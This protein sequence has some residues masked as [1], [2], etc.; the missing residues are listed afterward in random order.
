MLPQSCRCPHGEWRPHG[1][2][3]SS[4]DEKCLP[5]SS[6]KTK[7]TWLSNLT[8]ITCDLWVLARLL[9]ESDLSGT[10]TWFLHICK[11]VRQNSVWFSQW[12]LCLTWAAHTV[13]LLLMARSWAIRRKAAA[14][15]WTSISTS[16]NWFL[17]WVSLLREPAKK[18]MTLSLPLPVRR[19]STYNIKHTEYIHCYLHVIP[20]NLSSVQF[21]CEQEPQFCFE[22]Y[23]GQLVEWKA[24]CCYNVSKHA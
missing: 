19:R 18:A 15:V 21:M 17:W 23:K 22:H 13:R 24:S 14:E 20:F 1:I 8:S 11:S 12:F 6:G 16:M 10:A 9:F 7:R 3:E 2:W 5:C 4:F